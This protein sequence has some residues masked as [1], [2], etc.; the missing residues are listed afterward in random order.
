[1]RLGILVRLGVVFSVLL[2]PAVASAQAENGS[3]AGVARDASGAVLPGV[4]DLNVLAAWHLPPSHLS[5]LNRPAGANRSAPRSRSSL[6]THGW[7]KANSR[8][9]AAGSGQ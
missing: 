9:L 7:G 8:Q 5:G 4:G 2:L 3:I 6:Q 1:M